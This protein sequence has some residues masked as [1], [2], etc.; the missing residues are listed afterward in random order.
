L[1]S[2]DVAEACKQA[3]ERGEGFHT[4][5]KMIIHEALEAAKA[6]RKTAAL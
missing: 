2:R 1:G 3:R 4:Y 5:L 6:A